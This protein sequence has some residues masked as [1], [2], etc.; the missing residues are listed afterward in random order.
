MK[1]GDK[2][3]LHWHLINQD[4]T[5]FEDPMAFDITRAQRMPDLAREHRAFGIGLHF[6][7]GAHLA[8]MELQIMFEELLPRLRNP[9]LSEPV[10]YMRDYF[11]NGI[12][13][14]KITFD[15]EVESGR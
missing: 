11:V 13:E 2:V 5:I 8:R 12:K 14:M 1:E 9:Q 15:P 10:K 4:E 6:C 3:L 7:L